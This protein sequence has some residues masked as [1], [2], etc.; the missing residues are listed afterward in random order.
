VAPTGSAS[1]DHLVSSSAL[2][3]GRAR[4]RAASGGGTP[5]EQARARGRLAG[6]GSL[7]RVP[8]RRGGAGGAW[9]AVGDRDAC[10]RGGA[11]TVAGRG[12]DDTRQAGRRRAGVAGKEETNRQQEPAARERGRSGAGSEAGGGSEIGSREKKR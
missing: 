2:G 6:G 7:R 4:R 3:V 11:E 10:R 8:T 12:R 5:A 9:S 1:P